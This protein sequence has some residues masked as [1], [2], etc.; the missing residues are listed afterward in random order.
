LN[1][2]GEFK[3]TEPQPWVENTAPGQRYQE[4][5]A[6]FRFIALV[7][8]FIIWFGI[9]E[10]AKQMVIIAATIFPMYL[11]IYAGVRGAIQS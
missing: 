2:Q 5:T 4:P 10:L 8:L 7:P 11:N 9:D 3:P 1:R 6:G